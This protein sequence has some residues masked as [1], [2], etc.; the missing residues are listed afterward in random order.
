MAVRSKFTSPDLGAIFV[1]LANVFNSVTARSVPCQ[2]IKNVYGF[3]YFKDFKAPHAV[4]ALGPWWGY[5]EV[6]ALY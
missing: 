3:V 2:R 1:L 4:S 5:I 6:A